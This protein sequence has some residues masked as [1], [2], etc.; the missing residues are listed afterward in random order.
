MDKMTT[1]KTKTRL[2]LQLCELLLQPSLSLQ[3]L[4]QPRNFLNQINPLWLLC[5][6]HR[7]S[8]YLNSVPW[9]KLNLPHMF[10]LMISVWDVGDPLS[11]P[12]LLGESALLPCQLVN[13]A[14]IKSEKEE[15]Q[16][17][18]SLWCA[19]QWYWR[20]CCSLQVRQVRQLRLGLDSTHLHGRIFWCRPR[21]E[22]GSVWSEIPRN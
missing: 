4:M 14:K 20:S 7:A 5:W 21:P 2:I 18:G 15:E 11:S 8:L 22:R 3:T 12:Q 6:W 10:C 1:E 9:S 13:V 17:R 16:G 19:W